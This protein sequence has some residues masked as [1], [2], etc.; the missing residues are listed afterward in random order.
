MNRSIE[1]EAEVLVIGGGM[2]GAAA[3]L[4][5]AENGLKTCLA[6]TGWGAT[7]LSSGGFDLTGVPAWLRWM[8]GPNTDRDKLITDAVGDFMRWIRQAGHPFEGDPSG[9]LLL[10]NALGTLKRTQLAPQ[11]VWAGNLQEAE[12]ASLL[13]VGFTGY[14]GIQVEFLKESLEFFSRQGWLP[15]LEVQA[16]EVSLP[17]LR[18]QANLDSFDLAQLLDSQETS[19]ELIDLLRSKQ[20][21]DNFSHI[22]FPAVLGLH[23]FRSTQAMLEAESGRPCFEILSTPPSVPGFR[24]QRALDRALLQAGVRVVQARV[25]SFSVRN[26]YINEVLLGHKEGRYRA[27]PQAVILATGKFIGGGVEWQGT[28]RETSFDLPVFTQGSRSPALGMEA[29]LNNHFTAEQPVFSAGVRLDS[30]LRPASAEG[31]VIYQNLMAAG[32]IASGLDVVQGDGGLGLAL[33]SGHLAGRL[34][35]T[36]VRSTGEVFA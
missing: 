35:C 11:A 30:Q 9:E 29:L 27:A 1:E 33:V 18:R 15:R 13:L 8:L 23:H 10:L 12:G 7:S 22:A 5:A 28:L 34:A 14:T 16:V 2:A 24:L 25:L 26:G 31:K 32:S 20:N 6:R 4:S 3:A 17:R 36:L 19:Q 21:L